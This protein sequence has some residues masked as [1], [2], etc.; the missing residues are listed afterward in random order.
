MEKIA[1]LGL[2]NMGCGMAACL[3]K[4][5][6]EMTVYNRTAGRCDELVKQ[7]AKT[8]NT[9]REAVRGAKVVFSMVADNEASRAM[10]L[11]D[12][13]A[14]AGAEPGAMLIECSTLS[15]DW[16]EQLSDLARQRGVSYIDAPVTG[17]PDDAAAGRLGL[18]VGADKNDLDN[19]RKY[20]MPVAGQIIH[21][22]DVGAGTAFKL[23][24]NLMGAVQIAA[25][26]EGL[27]M[28]EAAG[29]DMDQ[30]VGAIGDGQAASP[31]VVR[32][33][34]RMVAGRHDSDIIFTGNLRLKDALYG[35]RLAGG[36]GV[37]SDFGVLAADCFQ[38]LE[39]AGEGD[40]NECKVIDVMRRKS[41]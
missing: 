6:F 20:L 30:V 11:G 2:G 4:A 16:V 39:Y 41:G 19:A 13:G 1:F 21:F 10:W 23:I 35:V 32:N 3:L 28:A 9:P 38:A 26:A 14:L 12:D 34:Q 7:G 31:Q 29:L 15:K 5:G 17:L 33:T 18:F 37:S 8:A 27:V 40:L 24:I 36:L 22:G 25:A